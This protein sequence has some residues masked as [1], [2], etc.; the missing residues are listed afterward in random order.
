MLDLKLLNNELIARKDDIIKF[1]QK[2]SSVSKEYMDRLPAIDSMDRPVN[3]QLPGYS[4]CKILEEGPLLHPFTT[5]FLSRQDATDWAMRVLKNMTVAAVDGS[6]IY[7][8]RQFSVP[9]GLAQAG[10]VVNRHVSVGSFSSSSKMSLI[11]P[12]DFE[13]AGGMYAYSQAPVSLKRHELECDRI[14]EFMRSEPGSIVF[15]DGS[16]VMSFINQIDDDK[17]RSRYADAIV[18]ILNASIETKTPVVAYTDMSLNKD[19]IN[20][21][22]LYFRLPPTSHLTDTYL[23]K[24]LLKWGDRTRTFIC[25]RDDRPV[26]NS[27]ASNKN[28]RSVLDLYGDHRDTIAFFYIQS[29]GGLPSKVEI[30]LWCHDAGM[31]DRIA[32]VVRAQCI[33]RPGY[34]DIIHR[35]HDYCKIGHADADMFNGVI[36][37]FAGRNNVKIYKSAK[38]FNKLLEA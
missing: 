14:V 32:D 10:I 33:V 26:K 37:S 28:N 6:Q 31:I 22:R 21:M 5:R 36:E 8:S 1:E 30:P 11:I 34:P 27:D 13:D 12:G 23:L 25:D 24:G 38:E 35:S 29:S 3:R 2:A 18:S 7:P 16:I 15:F 20:M 17:I 9:I 19:L 4:G